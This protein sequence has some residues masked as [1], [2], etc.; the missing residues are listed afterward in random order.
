MVKL[1][2]QTE[3]CKK[4]RGFLLDTQLLGVEGTSQEHMVQSSPLKRGQLQQVSQGCVQSSF[5]C[6][7]GER[8][9]NF[10]RQSVPVLF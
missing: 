9:Y 6:V 3:K 2:Q 4:V 8:L 5:E 1:L 10:S 7:R